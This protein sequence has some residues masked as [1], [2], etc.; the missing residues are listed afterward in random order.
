M[1]GENENLVAYA[2]YDTKGDL[3]MYV[4]EKD[5]KRKPLA[6]S[7]ILN[8]GDNISLSFATGVVNY[9]TGSS[10]VEMQDGTK[11]IFINAGT[12]DYLKYNTALL[13]L[14]GSFSIEMR[15]REAALQRSTTNYALFS[16]S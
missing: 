16:F 14:T 2:P 11:G 8:N 10:F 5:K 9:I 7:G 6:S 1:T 15:V 12:S 3:N 4:G 13:H